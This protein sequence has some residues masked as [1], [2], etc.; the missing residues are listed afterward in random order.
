MNALFAG[1]SSTQKDSSSDE[2]K[3]EPPKKQ[4][5][6]QQA[7]VEQPK[8]TAVT[9]LLS[10]DAPTTSQPTSATLPNN[11]SLLDM[12]NTSSSSQPEPEP[13]PYQPMVITTQQFGGMWG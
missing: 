2:E 9:D 12:L 4:A 8:Q 10:W 11:T 3:K 5:Q 7:V 6:Q 13:V 1:V